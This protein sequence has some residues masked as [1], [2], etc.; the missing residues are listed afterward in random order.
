MVR[1]FVAL[2]VLALSAAAPASAQYACT[3]NYCISSQSTSFQTPPGW[4]AVPVET[5]C[6]THWGA[7]PG[8]IRER[9]PQ[10]RRPEQSVAGLSV[11]LRAAELR[12]WRRLAECEGLPLRNAKR[13]THRRRGRDLRRIFEPPG[14]SHELVGVRAQGAETRILRVHRRRELPKE[15]EGLLR[16]A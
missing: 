11:G 13:S 12:N 4:P 5:C 2:S 6:Q 8:G 15:R 3:T 1:Y 9:I 10:L 16:S 14:S 7:L